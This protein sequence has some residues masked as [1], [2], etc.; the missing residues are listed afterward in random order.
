LVGG[1]IA[2]NF[3]LALGN[4]VG[5]SLIDKN[6]LKI[7]KKLYSKKIILPVD[8][9]VSDRADGREK[10]LVKSFD[11]VGKKD[12][13]FDIGPETIKLYSEIIKEAETIVWNGPLGKFESE[14]FK[15]GTL[16]IARIIA[17][18]SGGKAFGIAGGGETIEA[19]KMSGMINYIDW[20]ST[21]GGAMLAFLGGEKMP[22]LKGILK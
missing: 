7:A 16:A 6:Y 9:I 18:K 17:A 14:H 21:G 13:I 10:I 2:N 5:R 22:G 19:L 8:V 3:L 1:A 12:F 20:V 15:H 11:K 4:E